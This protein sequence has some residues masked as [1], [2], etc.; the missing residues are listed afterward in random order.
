MEENAGNLWLY[1]RVCSPPKEALKEIRGGRMNGKTDINPMWRLKMLTE[2][3]GPCGIGWKYEITRQ[4]LETSSTGETSA[5]CNILLYFKQDGAWSE[6]IPGTGGS[7]FVAREKGGM[8]VSDECY[9][10]ALTDAI[11]V[12]CKALGVAGNIYWQNDP[13]KYGGN[14]EEKS[15]NNTSSGADPEPVCQRCGS[16]VNKAKSKDGTLHTAEEM[17]RL[18]LDT[19]GKVLCLSCQRK[20]RQL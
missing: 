5:F 19:Y 10:M 6:G 14:R 4:W 18:S 12:A 11:S 1:N 13:T 17:A 20:E 2:Q 16:P 3:F 7:A 9:K 15:G 8:Y